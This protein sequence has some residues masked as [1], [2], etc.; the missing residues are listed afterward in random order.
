MV[1]TGVRLEVSNP[2]QTLKQKKKKKSYRTH[3]LS[4]LDSY[5]HI[6]N[7]NDTAIPL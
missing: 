6:K 2:L 5:L 4:S 7:Q 3:D 1:V